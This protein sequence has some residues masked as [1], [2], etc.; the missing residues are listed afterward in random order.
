[1]VH[2]IWGA[3]VLSV[4]E[5]CGPPPCEETLTCPRPDDTSRGGYAGNQ[6]GTGGTAGSSAGGK[7]ADT[8]GAGTGG[9]ANTSAGAAGKAVGVGGSG[10]EGPGAEAGEAGAQNGASG[11]SDECAT[12]C[13]DG[14]AAN[15]EELCVRGHCVPGN[16]PPV[17]VSVAPTDG[18]TEVDP[19]GTIR[20]TFSEELDPATVSANS[21]AILDGTEPV[22]GSVSYSGTRA[23]FTPESDLAL[24]AEYTVSVKSAVTDLDGLSMLDDFA[25]TFVVRDGTWAQTTSMPG[26]FAG[27]S[28]DSSGGF[29]LGWAGDAPYVTHY[30]MGSW[31]AAKQVSCADC[32]RYVFSGNRRGDA[33]AVA[34]DPNAVLRARQYREGKWESEDEDIADLTGYTPQAVVNA[35]IA[36]TGEG[37]VIVGD[38]AVLRIRQTDSIG[39]WLEGTDT[40]EG[41]YSASTFAFNEAGEGLATWA[42]N[43][44]ANRAVHLVRLHAGTTGSIELIPSSV[45]SGDLYATSSAVAADG[46]AMAVWSP[47]G[48]LLA[49][50]LTDSGWSNAQQIERTIG[51]ALCTD[52]TVVADGEDFV[53]AWGQRTGDTTTPCLVYTNWWH[54]G[55]W[56]GAELRSESGV[57][58]DSGTPPLLGSDPHGNLMLLWTVAETATYTRFIQMT[59]AWS[60]PT[61]AFDTRV[62]AT[63]ALAVAHGGTLI[64]AFQGGGRVYD[65][66]FQ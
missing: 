18:A 22:A 21:I 62:G 49:S 61:Q 28:T 5:G 38:D 34:V 39:G 33:I 36:P 66:L 47:N 63:G 50:H 4:A 64:G 54:N 45:T 59:G 57:A 7:P 29:M 14:N 17:V 53:A 13:D 10:V 8:F 56:S 58:T 30:E 2:C 51:G 23:T 65:A 1:M 26:Q 9:A 42:A 25:S 19:S 60:A 16:A 27:V 15:G 37:Y 32:F 48:D 55:S 3:L 46:E 41:L 20:I 31:S 11:S 24:L 40:D 52:P 35:A 43:E 6:G 12:A 44:G